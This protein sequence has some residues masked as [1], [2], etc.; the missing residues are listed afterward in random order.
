MFIQDPQV[1]L[2]P[3][4][5]IHYILMAFL[6]HFYTASRAAPQPSI[7]FCSFQ[8]PRLLCSNFQIFP[9]FLYPF[10]IVF[11]PLLGRSA[12]LDD[13]LFIQSTQ[14]VLQPSLIVVPLFSFSKAS[15]WQCKVF[16]DP[17]LWRSRFMDLKCY[18]GSFVLKADRCVIYIIW[19]S[20][21]LRASYLGHA[22][23]DDVWISD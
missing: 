22:E 2:Q 21:V 23:C 3:S 18:D 13:V 11:G 8:A 14:A 20:I 16:V 19:Y 5:T 10:K 9:F 1:V 7:R 12:A 17:T 4:L 15:C 6:S